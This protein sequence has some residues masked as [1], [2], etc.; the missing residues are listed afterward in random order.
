M[1]SAKRSC[2]GPAAGEDWFG[3]YAGF[4]TSGGNR[5]LSC[6]LHHESETEENKV[7]EKKIKWP[8]S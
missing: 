8:V 3:V 5:Q 7:G 2:A 1:A 6:V 4:P